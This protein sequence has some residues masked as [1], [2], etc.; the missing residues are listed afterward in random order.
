MADLS[1]RLNKSEEAVD[2]YLKIPYLYPKDTSLVIKA[3]LR[4]ARIFEDKEDWANAKI[5]YDKIMAYEVDE[6]TFAQERLD[7]INKYLKIKI[8]MKGQNYGNLANERMGTND[9]RRPVMIP[10]IL[11]RF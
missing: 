9:R 1:E 5:I 7:Q 3:Y 4:A 6:K 11:V 8:V 10:I 2:E